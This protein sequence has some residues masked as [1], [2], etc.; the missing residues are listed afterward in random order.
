MS[1]PRAN[2]ANTP[3]QPSLQIPLNLPIQHP[4]LIDDIFHYS[5]GLAPISVPDS[6]SAIRHTSLPST[7]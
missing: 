1:E 4:I 2:M 3:P 5:N 6:N 7:R